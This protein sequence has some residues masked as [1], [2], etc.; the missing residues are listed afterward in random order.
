[1]FERGVVCPMAPS[2]SLLFVRCFFFSKKNMSNEGS[3]LI[4][5]I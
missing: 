1:M 2:S 3:S 5:F 4:K